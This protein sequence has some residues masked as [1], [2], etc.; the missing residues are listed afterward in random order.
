MPL[1]SYPTNK[2][3]RAAAMLMALLGFSLLPSM[4]QAS[5]MGQ[6]I[7]VAYLDNGAYVAS[8]PNVT[9]TNGVE[10]QTGDWSGLLRG[11]ESI[12]VGADTI[13]YLIWG[14]GGSYA[15][16]PAH[17]VAEPTLY[18]SAGFGPTAQLIFTFPIGSFAPDVPAGVIIDLTGLTGVTNDDVTF[19]SDTVTIALGNVG[20]L[21]QAGSSADFGTLMLSLQ[22]TAPPEPLPSVPEPGTLALLGLGFGA[23]GLRR[24]TR[25]HVA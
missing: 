2:N 3:L 4:A 14:S 21:K 11:G 17:A 6:N 9:V 19:A 13:A 24:R 18:T 5:L 15:P 10:S 25:R 7:S 20:V 12:D 22:V 23:L 16:D 1:F 8:V